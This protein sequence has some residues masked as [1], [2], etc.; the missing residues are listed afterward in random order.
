MHRNKLTPSFTHAD[1]DGDA[2]AD[3]DG[4]VGSD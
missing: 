1:V 2:D 4:I 3:A